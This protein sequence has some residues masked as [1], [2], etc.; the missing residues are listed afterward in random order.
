MQAYSV[1]PL[2]GNIVNEVFEEWFYLVFKKNM[3]SFPP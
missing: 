3:P 1:Y 2:G